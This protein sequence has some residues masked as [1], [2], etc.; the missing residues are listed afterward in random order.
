MALDERSIVKTPTIGRIERTR[1]RRYNARL[2][3]GALRGMPVHARRRATA[4]ILAAAL[5]TAWGAVSAA[6][7]VP[8]S[9]TLPNGL[10]MTL[11][12]DHTLPVV[13]VSLWVGAGSKDESE[14]SAGYAHFLEHLIQRGTERVGPHEYTRRAHRWGGS[15]GVHA[16]YDRTSITLTGLPS[17]LDEMIQAAADMAFH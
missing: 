12:E 7:G 6:P 8:D 11:L 2:S 17:V 1:T 5:L 3:P 14:D 16:N 4:A 10:R 15:I 13:S 9:R